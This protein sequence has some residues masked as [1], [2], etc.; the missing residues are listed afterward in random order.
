M[1]KTISDDK[2]AVKSGYYFEIFEKEKIPDT[3]KKSDKIV[4][5]N[6]KIFDLYVGQSIEDERK[7]DIMFGDKLG[8][9]IDA[10]LGQPRE[11]PRCKLI[12]EDGNIFN[13]IAIASKTLRNNNMYKLAKE[14]EN[15]IIKGSKSYEEALG[16]IEEYVEI[17]GKEN[18][19]IEEY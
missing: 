2:V 13:L 1:D 16:V 3:L 19:E 12:G 7:I 15:R 17:T 14:M 6:G 18:E 8:Y 11:K 4:N 5:L 9:F 10:H